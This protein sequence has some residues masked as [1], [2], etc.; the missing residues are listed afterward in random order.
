MT[1]LE[2]A[3]SQ[4]TSRPGSTPITDEHIALAIAW[5]KDEI[6]YSQA[7]HALFNNRKA[8]TMQAYV[9]LARSLRE[10]MRQG[11]IKE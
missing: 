9:I 10:A 7:L 2:K 8:G 3:Q 11:L 4:P 6:N 5:A 1:L